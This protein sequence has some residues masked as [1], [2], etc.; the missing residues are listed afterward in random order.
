MP[1]VEIKTDSSLRPDFQKPIKKKFKKKKKKEIW[2][3]LV[4]KTRV[5][6]KVKF[7]K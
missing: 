1:A 7:T 6:R 4:H 5:H 3:N 2:Y